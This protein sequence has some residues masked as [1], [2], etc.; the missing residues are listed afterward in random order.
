MTADLVQFLRAR[1]DEDEQ[2]ARRA[3]DG[4]RNQFV[5]ADSDVVPLLFA[6]DG[7]GEFNLPA[8]VLAEVDAK[9]QALDHY[10]RIQQHVRKSD[11]GDDYIFAEGAVCK[12]LQYM[13]LPYRERPDYR[14]EWAPDQ[15]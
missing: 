9:R 12:Q 2:R 15:A 10:E 4:P 8:R 3:I 7:E 6:D 1:L 5:D 13:A 14:P 11:G